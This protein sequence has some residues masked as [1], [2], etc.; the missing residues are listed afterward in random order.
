[1]IYTVTFNPSLDY[2]VSVDDFILGKVNRTSKELIYPGGKGINV[3]R[4]LKELGV[5]SSALG[6]IAGF[7]GDEIKRNLESDG[8]ATDFVRL[9]HG[10]SRINV[11]L[12]CGGETDINS[13]GP[14][15]R[16]DELDMLFDNLQA[17]S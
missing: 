15:I 1:M 14:E 8:I 11:K 12:R 7:T 17:V 3:S 16:Q 4:V 6:F 10:M 9:S 2:I 5:E 13:K